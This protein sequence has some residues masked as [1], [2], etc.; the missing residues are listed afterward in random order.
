MNGL[1]IH[2]G[3]LPGTFAFLYRSGPQCLA[4]YSHDEA[5]CYLGDDARFRGVGKMARPI[6]L[7]SGFPPCALFPGSISG[8]LR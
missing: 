4:S 6:S 1:A 2:G 8:A 3:F 5:A 7:W